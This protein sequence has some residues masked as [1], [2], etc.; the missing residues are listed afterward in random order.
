MPK[1]TFEVTVGIFVAKEFERQLRRA[2]I[3]NNISLDIE[4]VSG[5]L[6]T[7]FFIT[8]E[9]DSNNTIKNLYKAIKLV[10]R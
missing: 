9:A 7:S 8:I 4:K 6:Q 5:F 10:Q 3:K 2:C 1:G